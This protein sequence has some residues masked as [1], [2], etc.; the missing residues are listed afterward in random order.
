MKLANQTYES[1]QRNQYT[2]GVFID[3]SKA[4]ETGNHSV[5]IKKLQMY[6]IRG[7]NLAWFCRYLVNR[8]QYISLDHD[9]KTSTQNI[10]CGVP[11]GSILEPLLF[12]LHVSHLPNSSVLEP[13]MFA[14]DT[15]LFF[16]NIQ[17]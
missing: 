15:N 1:F 2:L 6:G 13:I 3:F 9:L 5:L 10:P 14:D 8:K 12:L 4:F 17:T 16:F 11:Q 7:A